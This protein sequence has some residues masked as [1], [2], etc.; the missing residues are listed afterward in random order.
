[1][2]LKIPVDARFCSFLTSMEK[3]NVRAL[4]SIKGS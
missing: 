2:I 1:M 3:L 4:M